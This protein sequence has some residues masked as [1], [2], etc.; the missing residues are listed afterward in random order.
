MGD[1]EF[2]MPLASTIDPYFATHRAVWVLYAIARLRAGQTMAAAQTEMEA[3]YRQIRR[4]HPEV[5]RDM[6]IRVTPLQAQISRD[7]RPA[8]LALLGAVALVLLTACANLAGL[9]S[10]RASARAREM[11]IRSALGA[12]RRRMIRQLL[13]ECLT[14]AVLGGLAGIGLAF[15]A[16]RGL[17]WLSKDPRLLGVGL[18]LP[19]LL[20]ALAATVA[21]SLLFGIMPAIH[22]ARI[23]AAEALKS[24]PRAGGG[25]KHAFARQAL[26][27]AQVALCLVLLVGAGLLFRSFRR[28]LEVNPGF[29]TDHLLSMRT[30]LPNSYKTAAA[31]VQV[32]AQFMG[33]IKSLP[34]VVDATMV[35]SLP[36]SGGDANG[37]LTV[38]G[39]ASGPGDL[40]AVSF[41]RALPGYFRAMGIPLIR[42]RDFSGADDPRHEQV[43]IINENMAR[44]FW[45]GQ[46]PI[47]RRFKI[48]P[49]DTAKWIT[50]VG[51]VRDVRHIGLDSE[52]GFA[53]YQPVS[54]QPRLQME[55]AIRTAGDP[56][57]VIAAA[58]R[59]LRS[60]EPRLLIDKVQTMSQRID[61]SVAPRRLNLV[62]FGLFSWLA[63]ALAAL[64]LYGVAAYAAGQRT[65]EF[66]IRVAL[67]ARSADVRRLVL[68]QGLKLAAAGVVIGTAA[69]LGLTRLLTKLL[70]GIEPADPLT[71]IAMA[72]LLA[73]VATLACWVP[74][75]RATR[76]APT[77]ALRI[78]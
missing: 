29:R 23:D 69:A 44:R 32:Y 19:V 1:S 31:V 35:S 52:T 26:V 73:C 42:G 71:I 65:R 62:L 54:Q 43:T 50:I 77:E 70:F 4:E 16:T 76:V 33:R 38:E 2:W 51:V 74:A 53:T 17:Q 41:R 20:F 5:N 8:L 21:T 67:G 18:D 36:I 63:L 22:A 24:G 61:D 78:E 27:V 11:A 75:H 58:Q 47:G 48:G 68:R 40:A 64:G 60:I 49:Q 6:A 66:G 72:M 13:T 12:G 39:L 7:L 34:G 30:G 10:V 56:A 3:I 25:P 46:D 55:L 14:L 15:W 28:V 45:P 9:M 37:D 57:T 59:E